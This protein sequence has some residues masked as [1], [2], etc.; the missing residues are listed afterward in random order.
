MKS[1][2][3]LFKYVQ[4]FFREYLPHER[5]LSHNTIH[6]YRD[7][8][9]LFL[10][11][12]ASRKGGKV[13]SLSLTDLTA[14]NVGAFLNMLET[15]RSVSVRTRNQR[16]AVLKTFFSYMIAQDVTRADQ[17][18]KIGLIEAKRGPSRPMDYLTEEELDAILKS[19]DRTTDQG[20]RDYTIL[21][22]LYNT[23]ARVQEICDLK[24]SDVRLKT[25]LMVTLTGKGNKTRHVPLWDGTRQA[26]E[27]YLNCR[28][29]KDGAERIFIG[30]RGEPLSRFG[31]R[32]LV[33]M[34]VAA[35]SKKCP[36]LAKKNIGPHTFRHTTGMHLLQSGVDLAVIQSWLGHADMNTTHNYIDIDMKMKEKALAKGKQPESAR[37]I[38]KI[39]EKEKDVLTWLESL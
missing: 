29:A 19:V 8:I 25:P 21:L 7:T 16:L 9:K 12:I 38:R 1:S 15:T 24:I 3:E 28:N 11:D 33:K 30:K 10:Q 2:K 18:G 13:Q 26:I 23:G 37:K 6:S 14:K 22:L 27:E 35:A 17:Y 34:R 20:C 5:G 36:A 32:Y 31:I 39:L 4:T